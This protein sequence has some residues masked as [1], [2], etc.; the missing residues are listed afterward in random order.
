MSDC[1]CDVHVIVIYDAMICDFDIVVV[2]YDSMLCDV[3]V[4]I[5]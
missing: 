3:V 2:I 4:V 1:V 5:V